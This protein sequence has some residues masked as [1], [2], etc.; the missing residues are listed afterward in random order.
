MARLRRASA[1]ARAHDVAIYA[2]LAAWFYGRD[3][4]QTGGAELQATLLA[5]ELSER[6]LRVA[7]V[8]YAHPGA[9]ALAEPG[10]T[11]VQRPRPTPPR[12]GR[13]L[14]EARAIWGALRRADATV[15]VVRGSGGYVVP[16]A[17]F[18]RATR[19]RFVFSSS[20]DLDFDF[21]RTDREPRTLAAYRRAVVR[22]DRVVLQ[23]RQQLELAARALPAT[24][25]VVIPSFAQ[26]GKP[27]AETPRY[28]LWA[29]RLVRYKRPDCYVALAEA[30]PEA[31]FRIVFST[32]D[33][34]EPELI[35]EMH[36]ATRRL[37]NFEVLP[38]RP[39]E[40]LLEEMHYAAALVTTSRVEGMPNTFLE[41]WARGI[42]VLS[43]HVDPDDR[44]S[45]NEI[46]FV[47]GGSMERFVQDAR[48]LWHDRE[49]RAE[50]G[51]RAQA[52]VRS[53]HAPEAVADK[54]QALIREL[55]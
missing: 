22:A 1:R 28:F 15:T 45:E 13:Q 17:G 36:E 21:E 48:S 55:L 9:R 6:G 7:H 44:V 26:L 42:P 23:T 51:R 38:P 4:D 18:A 10:P 29:G 31:S 30:I 43:L 12:R 46:G 32:T 16:V 2:P 33:E 34:T 52:F 54:W 20:S 11:L 19:R 27:A 5:H 39:R 47:A 37:P 24:K 8:I 49:L 25:P 40:T 35:E 50:I 3:S 53:T 14:F 41:A